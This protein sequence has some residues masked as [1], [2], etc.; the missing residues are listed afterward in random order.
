VTRLDDF[1]AHYA[2]TLEHWRQ[3]FWRHIDAVRRLGFD[4]RF[5]RMWHYYLCYCEAGFLDQQIGVAQIMLAKPG[6][7][8]SKT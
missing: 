6:F 3:R 5:I 2:R 1:G 4:E 7:S 8:C